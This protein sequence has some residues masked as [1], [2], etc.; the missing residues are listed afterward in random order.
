MP[1]STRAEG[2]VWAPDTAQVRVGADGFVVRLLA[3][4]GGLVKRG[5]PLVET[6]DPFIRA[7]VRR[8]EAR[9]EELEARLTEEEFADQTRANVIRQQILSAVADLERARERADALVIVSPVDGV[10][11]L[12]NSADLPGRFLRRGEL[13]GYV[14]D[15]SVTT[16]RVVIGQD[17]IGLVRERTEAVEVRLAGWSVEPLPATIGRAVPAATDTLPT[18]ALGV[19]GGGRFLVDSRGPSGLRTLE[20]VFQLDLVLAEQV[21]S[22]AARPTS[23]RAVRP[24]SRGAGTPAVPR[25]SAAL[26]QPFQCL[27][28]DTLVRQRPRRRN[29][30]IGLDPYPERK[31][32]ALG[33][34]DLA[35]AR[36]V[37]FLR[38]RRRQGT[39]ALRRVVA[40]VASHEPGLMQAGSATIAS[41]LTA[42]STALGHEGLT[43]ALAGRAFALVR[44]S[45]R[46]TLGMRH[47][48]VQI[49]GG[50]AMLRGMLAEMQTGEGKT[51][52]ATLPRLRCGPRRHPGSR[53]H[54]QR[55]S[56]HPRRRV[57]PPAL[58]RPRTQCGHHHGGNGPGRAPRRVCM[59]R[60]LLHQ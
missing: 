1:L 6:A 26:P 48:D 9:L 50:W 27:G 15:E 46:R 44:E 59:Q 41:E 11:V 17:N 4:V 56:G 49:M 19:S 39:V 57:A 13:V 3:P 10:F 25:V 20:M 24:R 47:H 42:L 32:S 14:T 51:V 23:E 35:A 5:Q 31:E 22:G 21:E 16:V 58:Y 2:I 54:G 29:L 28:P 53:G 60:D 43:D 38:Q 33:W 40:R 12:P 34:A 7:G 30:G 37:G 18:Q 52:T 8:R 36:A 45:A 55:L